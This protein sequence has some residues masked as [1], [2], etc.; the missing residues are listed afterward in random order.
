[1]KFL[2]WNIKSNLNLENIILDCICENSVDIAV[3]SEYENLDFKNL[4]QNLNNNYKLLDSFGGCEKVKVLFHRNVQL[5]LLKE[6]HRYLLAKITHLDKIYL[7]ACAHLPSNTHSNSDDRKI[8]IRKIINDISFYEANKISSSIVIGDM[9]ASPFDTEMVGKD[10]FNSVLFKDIIRRSDQITYHNEKYR[11][12]YNPIIEYINEGTKSYGSFYYQAGN[13]CLY[14]Y[15]YDQLLVRKE[16]IDNILKFDYLK[17][18]KNTR[19]LKNSKPNKKIS[20][21][22]PLLVELDI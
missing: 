3:F 4:I 20:D 18:I 13:S 5:T 10:S 9:N 17:Q 6:Q 1:M 12:F 22:L 2:Y 7:L 15:C 19:L 16:L 21:H 8:E 14:W 11:R